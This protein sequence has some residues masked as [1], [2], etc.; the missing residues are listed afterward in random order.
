MSAAAIGQNKLAVAEDYA[1][2]AISMF[3]L[4]QGPSLSGPCYRADRACRKLPPLGPDLG[5][6]ENP[7]LSRRFTASCRRQSGRTAAAFNCRGELRVRQ[8]NWHEAEQL[9][10]EAIGIQ[11]NAQLLLAL[12][13]VL[14]HEG[15]SV[16]EVRA[17]E[18]QAR[19]MRRSA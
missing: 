7:A 16:D 10:R 5:G 19:G 11:G 15:G 1:L 17:L 2:R 3:R 18:D 12:A 13:D 14:K 6:G 9:F 4:Q 8:H